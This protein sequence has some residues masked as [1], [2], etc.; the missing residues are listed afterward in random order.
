MYCTNAYFCVKCAGNHSTSECRKSKD[1][2]PTYVLCNGPHPA[3]YKGC[4][5][6]KELQRTMLNTTAP[7]KQQ[8]STTIHVHEYQPER[9]NLT[10]S[11]AIKANT[12]QGEPTNVNRTVTEFLDRFE[13]MFN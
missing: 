13:N 2:P 7:S 4:T 3:N 6:Y 9:E 12:Q 10:Y 5:D 8:V 11:Q 1:S